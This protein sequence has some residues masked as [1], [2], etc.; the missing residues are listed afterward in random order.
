MG[1]RASAI[2]GDKSQGLRDRVMND[3]RRGYA[4]VLVATDVA[5]RG[6]DVKDIT[7]VVNFDF[8]P[9]LED[10]VHRIGRT[11]RAG[12]TGTAVSFFTA[13]DYRLAPQL[14]RLMKDCKQDIPP[15]LQQVS[16]RAG[17]VGDFSWNRSRQPRRS[18]HPMT[19]NYGGRGFSNSGSG[20][21]R[22]LGF[23]TN[24]GKPQRRSSS[25]FDAPSRNRSESWGSNRSGSWGSNRSGSG[26]LRPKPFERKDGF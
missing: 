21:R 24:E 26:A 17:P 23:G 9:T 3:F 19:S 12:A 15:S 8:P 25:F 1:V 20:E 18:Y 14:I 11:A 10:Y 4:S 6:L 5:A 2:H 22:S 13:D 7:T 16:G